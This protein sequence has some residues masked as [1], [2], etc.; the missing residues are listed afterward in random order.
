MGSEFGGYVISNGMLEEKGENGIVWDTDYTMNF[1]EMKM[2]VRL[3]R[4]FTEEA[5]AIDSKF[6]TPHFITLLI[7]RG[8]IKEVRNL[9]V[10]RTPTLINE[11]NIDMLADIING[12]AR[13]R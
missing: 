10:L 12:K 1:N 3:D 6:S 8:Y 7:E 13:Y 4:S 5:L 9:P 11:S 2:A